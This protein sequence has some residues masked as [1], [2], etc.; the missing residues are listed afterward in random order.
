MQLT[1]DDM[2]AIAKSRVNKTEGKATQTYLWLMFAGIALGFII[3]YFYLVWVGYGIVAI[4]LVGFLY[5]NSKLI[6][7]QNMMEAR[8][9][10]EWTAEQKVNQ[11]DKGISNA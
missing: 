10:K 2:K 5:Y 9:I 3:S 7:K 6:K 1:R 8:L 4:S 11:A